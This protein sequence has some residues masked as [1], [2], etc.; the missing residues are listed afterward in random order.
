[1]TNSTPSDDNTSGKKTGQSP[2]ERGGSATPPRKAPPGIRRKPRVPGLG[3]VAGAA[4]SQA[5]AAA[6]TVRGTVAGTAGRARA[7][8]AQVTKGPGEPGGCL[9]VRGISAAAR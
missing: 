4:T 9:E 5:K 8:G 2:R 1:M 6:G 7:A 3:D